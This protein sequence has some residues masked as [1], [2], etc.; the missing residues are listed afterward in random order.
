MEASQKTNVELP[1]DP[2]ILL[3]VMYLKKKEN[4]NSKKYMQPNVL[5]STVHNCQIWKQP[6]HPSTDE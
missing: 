3:L 2:A 5:S 4:A 6:K 1:Y